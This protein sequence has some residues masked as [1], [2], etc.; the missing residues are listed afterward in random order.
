MSRLEIERLFELSLDLLC[1]AGFDGY[2]KRLNPAWER[3]LGFPVQELLARP[4]L[5]F[6]D[7][8]QGDPASREWAAR[9]APAAAVAGLLLQ[10]RKSA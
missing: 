4:Y 6:A 9:A 2:F 5:D 10:L 7:L 3:T 8:V 1:I